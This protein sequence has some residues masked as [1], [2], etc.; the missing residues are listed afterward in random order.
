MFFHSVRDYEI[1]YDT[2]VS[3]PAFFQSR[4]LD[5]F[6]VIVVFLAIIYNYVINQFSKQQAILIDNIKQESIILLI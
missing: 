1:S 5:F 2:N 6:S 3:H 4:F